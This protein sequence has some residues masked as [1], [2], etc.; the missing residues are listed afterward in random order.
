MLRGSSARR[1]YARPNRSRNGRGPTPV[2]STAGSFAGKNCRNRVF[3]GLLTSETEGDRL[4][5]PGKAATL[6]LSGGPGGFLGVQ[7]TRMGHAYPLPGSMAPQGALCPK[8][9]RLPRRVPCMPEGSDPV[10]GLGQGLPWLSAGSRGVVGGSVDGNGC[11]QTRKRETGA[12]G[13]SPPPITPVTRANARAVCKNNRKA[14]VPSWG[15][16]RAG[17]AERPG[18]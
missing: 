5:L 16:G 12:Q 2:Q 17:G 7:R 1:A 8:L 13:C 15:G 9:A 4:F 3:S 6:A 11:Y 18:A 14:W 10:F